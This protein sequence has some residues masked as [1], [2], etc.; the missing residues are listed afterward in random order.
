MAW[1]MKA[2]TNSAVNMLD[3]SDCRRPGIL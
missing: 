3:C 2:Q 1:D